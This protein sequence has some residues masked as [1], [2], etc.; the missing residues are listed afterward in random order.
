M[1]TLL[2]SLLLALTFGSASGQDLERPEDWKVRFDQATASEADLEMFVAMPPGWHVTSG[3]AAIYWD[4]AVTASGDFRVEMEV[5]LFEP[6]DRREAFGLFVGGNDLEGPDQSYS[7]FLIRNGS[8]FIIK[9]RQGSE[10]PTIRPWTN[11]DAIVAWE[12]KPADAAT[13][14][15]VLALE[16]RGDSVTFL[17]NGA[18]LTTLP[19][20]ELD[21]SGTVGMRVNHGLNLHI[22]RLDVTPLS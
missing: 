6:G 19:R 20:S 5:Y 12:T 10:A 18:V 13:A 15:N 3:P 9:Q 8:E 16:A 2:A 17:A 14:K 7:Y 1:R 4:P 22:S 11:H 21:L